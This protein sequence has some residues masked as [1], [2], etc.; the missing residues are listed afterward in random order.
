MIL[1]GSL[2]GMPQKTVW[3]VGGLFLLSAL[4]PTLVALVLWKKKAWKDE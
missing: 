4:A 2:L 3:I 1:L